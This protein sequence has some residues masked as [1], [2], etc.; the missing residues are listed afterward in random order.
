[1]QTPRKKRTPATRR[2]KKSK[3]AGR[4]VE[5]SIGAGDPLQPG[6]LA[7]YAALAGEK[8]RATQ[9]PA[10]AAADTRKADRGAALKA[11]QAR[12]S[13]RQRGK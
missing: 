8:R 4:L 11:A 12:W 10:P 7:E 13:S 2:P 1:M 9:Q 6:G 3:V 5:L